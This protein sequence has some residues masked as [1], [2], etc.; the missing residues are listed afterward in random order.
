MKKILLV[1]TALIMLSLVGCQNEYQKK[2]QEM[3]NKLDELCQQKDVK[4][5]LALDD[6]INSLETQLEEAKDT[7]AL[8][9]FRD[10]INEARL[11]NAPYISSLKVD[12]GASKDSVVGD[13]I[14]DALNDG[15][16]DIGTVTSAI[17]AIN[18]KEAKK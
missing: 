1:V 7:L 10:A 3:A 18:E 6:S 5:V 8:K 9:E 16:F 17:D 12:A 13:L 14:N 4:A 2:G 15:N 11:R